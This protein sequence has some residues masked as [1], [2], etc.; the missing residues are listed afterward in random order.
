M[1]EN[2]MARRKTRKLDMKSW[3]GG[4]CRLDKPTKSVYK[5][6]PDT[7]LTTKLH[8]MWKTTETKMEKQQ[9]EA[10]RNK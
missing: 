7:W 8:M 4:N 2:L 9:L 5:V 1:E 10:E 6:H 3:K